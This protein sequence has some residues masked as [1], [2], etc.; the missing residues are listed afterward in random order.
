MIY[1]GKCFLGKPT[2]CQMPEY[3]CFLQTA[4]KTK[5]TAETFF[6]ERFRLR[7]ELIKR[8]PPNRLSLQAL[9]L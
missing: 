1:F 4:K 6:S 7:S 5:K 2:F 9:K 8:T 3:Q